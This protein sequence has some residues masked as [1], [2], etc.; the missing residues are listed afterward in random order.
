MS[1]SIQSGSSRRK[2]FIPVLSAEPGIADAF[3][4]AVLGTAEETSG[5]VEFGQ[6]RA[7]LEAAAPNGT[8]PAGAKVK[9]Q[10]A[11]AIVWLVHFMDGRSLDDARVLLER[12]AASCMA[13]MG[14]FIF[15]P[16]AERQF[17]I[18]CPECGQKLWVMEHEVGMRGRCVN[19]RRPMM[20]PT[21]SEHLRATL[22]LRDSVPVLNVVRSD[23]SLC[24][25]A[26]ANLLAR[27][28][29]GIH[30]DAGMPPE[31]F[32]K[33]A[34]VPIQLDVNMVGR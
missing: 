9:Y 2:L 6:Y 8:D 32:L 5:E 15:R 28:G 17:K 23:A 4:R 33:Q 14:V 31:D 20:I 16:E 19:C 1:A 25:G 34:T 13:P 11:D 3:V 30:A 7:F 26:L 29:S 27:T 12:V 24:R 22:R 18:S 10:Q 21:P